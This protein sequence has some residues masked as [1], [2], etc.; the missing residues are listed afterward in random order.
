MSTPGRLL[1]TLAPLPRAPSPGP[2][3][4]GGS[5]VRV[6]I[7]ISLR[8]SWVLGRFRPASGGEYIFNLFF[9]PKLSQGWCALG[10]GRTSEGGRRTRSGWVFSLL[11]SRV[12]GRWR[13]A[14]RRANAP[15][16]RPG[17]HHPCRSPPVRLSY[18]CMRDK[19]RPRTCE[20][21][22]SG[23][24]GVPKPYLY[25]LVTSMAPNPMI[26]HGFGLRIFRTHRCLT[27]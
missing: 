19:R 21:I 1:R 14:N 8:R 15:E 17:R 3:P 12:S 18:Q 24:M 6:R 23:A 22:G 9:G 25:G 16:H 10:D 26:A 13:R 2:P 27:V 4:P 11:F 7:V 20:F 5:R